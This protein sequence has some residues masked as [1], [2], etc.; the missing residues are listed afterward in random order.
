[1]RTKVYRHATNNSVEFFSV[2]K[3]KIVGDGLESEYPDEFIRT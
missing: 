1:M 2:V 3:V